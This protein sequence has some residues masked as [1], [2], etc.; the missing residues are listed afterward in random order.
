MRLRFDKHISA[1]VWRQDFATLC[2]WSLVFWQFSLGHLLPVV[3]RLSKTE[4]FTTFLIPLVVDRLALD[5]QRDVRICVRIGTL[6]EQ[7][8][9]FFSLPTKF[10]NDW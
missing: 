1:S 10:K 2:Q 3:I 9:L 7:W 8:V 4:D 5:D 6:N